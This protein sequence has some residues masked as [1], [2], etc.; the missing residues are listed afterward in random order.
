[1]RPRIVAIAATAL[2]VVSLGLAGCSSTGADSTGTTASQS[3]PG[4]LVAPTSPQRVDVDKF[5]EIVASPQSI[6]IDVR[7]PEEFA[8]GHL[9]GAV[10]YNVEGPDF[11]S[12][13]ATLDPAD[14]YAVYCRSG[15]RSQVAV[16]QMQKI[17]IN[18]IYELQTGFNAWQEAGYPVVY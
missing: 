12:Q 18:G 10:N 15:N 5:A 16:A 8:A 6:V 11:A 9:E 1:M 7:T 3:A 14:V 13:I 2:A 4:T 17:G